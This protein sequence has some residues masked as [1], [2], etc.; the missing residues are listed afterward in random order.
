MGNDCADHYGV[1]INRI[2]CNDHKAD[3][4][5]WIM[6]ILKMF[7]GLFLDKAVEEIK[8]PDEGHFIGGDKELVDDVAA[9][10]E[11]KIFSEADTDI[12]LPGQEEFDEALEIAKDDA[13]VIAAGRKKIDERDKEVYSHPN[14]VFHYCPHP[15]LCRGV[16][17]GCTIVN[18]KK[19]MEHG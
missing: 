17:V 5:S 18:K 19:D 13:V 7:F 9:D 2:Y 3:A 10:I 16:G 8:K 11:K 12:I 1:I 6:G 14:C 15:K 4:M